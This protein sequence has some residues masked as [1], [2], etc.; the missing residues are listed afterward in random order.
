MGRKGPISFFLPAHGY[1]G[2]CHGY[3][4]YSIMNI[5]WAGLAFYFFFLKSMRICHCDRY[6]Y[7]VN[8]K[9]RRKPRRPIGIPGLH[10]TAQKHMGRKGPISFFCQRTVV[11]ESIKFSGQGYIIHIS[12]GKKGYAEFGCHISQINMKFWNLTL[13]S[14]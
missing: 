8:P 14:F 1:W 12:L 4:K 13:M 10:R 5:A 2:S 3:T 9:S 6:S 7:S 11:N